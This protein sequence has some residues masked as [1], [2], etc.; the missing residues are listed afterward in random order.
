MMVRLSRAWPSYPRPFRSTTKGETTST[1]QHRKTQINVDMSQQNRKEKV[2]LIVGACGLDRLLSLSSYPVAD[3]KVRT[4][5][6]HEQGGGNA[7]NTASAMGRLL[8][9]RFLNAD[10]TTTTTPAIRI[11]LLTKIG[12]DDVGRQLIDEL[13][14][15]GVDTS[16]PLFRTSAP[17]TTTSFTTIVVSELEHTRTCFHTLG[18]CGELTVEDIQSVDLDD[19]FEDVVHLHS[20]ARHTAA[21]LYLVQQAKSRGIPVS[22][23]IEKDRNTKDLDQLLELTDLLFTNTTI[24]FGAYL[25]R[26]EQ[27]HQILDRRIPLPQATVSTSTTTTRLEAA[28]LSLYAAS[29]AP[30]AF[31]HRWYSPCDKTVIVT[32]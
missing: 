27:E 32:Q 30:I 14:E 6:Y 28:T 31:Y 26:L 13:H 18:S 2:V 16:S 11:K 8:D 23:D 20:D 3:A 29:L 4:R 21:S 17:R 5:T 15:F 7:A 24:H 19:V 12:P 1:I 25:Q 22:V 9:A 10:L